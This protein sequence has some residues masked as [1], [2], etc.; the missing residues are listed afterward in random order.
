MKSCRLSLMSLSLVVAFLA[1]V[2]YCDEVR[3]ITEPTTSMDTEGRSF[4]NE[5]E[6][7]R[8]LI[9]R[10]NQTN[11]IE[12]YPWRRAYSIMQSEPNV[13]LFPTTRTEARENDAKWVG[14]LLKVRWVMYAHK[15][16]DIELN[17]LE[18]A[19]KVPQI[20]GYLGDAKLAFLEKNGFENIET[21]YRSFDC[22]K[23]LARKRVDL[24]ISSANA[25][26]W[27]IQADRDYLS[28]IKIVYTID[29]KY[30]YYAVSK[31]TSDETVNLLQ[32][33]PQ[34]NEK[35]RR[36]LQILQQRLF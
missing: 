36:F 23:L 11:D 10:L 27:D 32:G 2:G 19:K 31:E 7:T 3:F 14:P 21:Q 12:V 30:L 9:Q 29:T 22:I 33:N 4:S 13:A 25:L 26:L 15:D 24:W 34:Y 8:E 20:C 35:R 17:N 18:D 16:S 1:P 6:L 5:S 28:D